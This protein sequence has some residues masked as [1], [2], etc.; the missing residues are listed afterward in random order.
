MTSRSCPVRPK[1]VLSG[2]SQKA[3]Q[4]AG[5]HPSSVSQ[6]LRSSP[7]RRKSS[8][9]WRLVQVGTLGG[10]GGVVEGRP[11][12]GSTEIWQL[13]PITSTVPEKHSHFWMQQ[14]GNHGDRVAIITL[15]AGAASQLHSDIL[16][17]PVFFFLFIMN[18]GSS[19]TGSVGVYGSVAS[20]ASSLAQ[21]ARP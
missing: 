5:F 11:R 15:S 16:S 13:Q 20:S 21:L 18:I 9:L 3:F 17:Y 7:G 6:Q 1:G 8:V 14:R 2:K 12:P 19:G 4:R 10:A